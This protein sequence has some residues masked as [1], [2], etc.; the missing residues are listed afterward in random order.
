MKHE[1]ILETEPT[2]IDTP[3]TITVAV[4]EIPQSHEVM[5]HQLRETDPD[6]VVE[7]AAGIGATA[8]NRDFRT[9]EQ[10][11][12]EAA[13]QKRWDVFAHRQD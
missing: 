9:P 8:L 10:Q 5:V 6:R 13:V 2:K 12:A 11:V 7:R 4:R 1:P 3:E